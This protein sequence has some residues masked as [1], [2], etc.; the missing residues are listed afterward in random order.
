M[1][2]I[3]GAKAEG[4]SSD[5]PRLVTGRVGAIIEQRARAAMHDVFGRLRQLHR[6]LHL[7]Q[8]RRISHHTTSIIRVRRL[9]T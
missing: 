3:V 8:C 6:L 5:R 7:R 4:R 2:S 9:T 1:E